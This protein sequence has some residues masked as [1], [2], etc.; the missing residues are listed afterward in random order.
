[1]DTVYPMC[2]TSDGIKDTENFLF[3]CP[4]V[5]VQWKD[6]LSAI[7]ELLRPVVQIADLSNDALIQ[8]LLYGDHNL[9]M[10]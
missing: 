1:M 2:P 8:L 10:T 5:D 3:L 6:V 9:L 7:V 4:S